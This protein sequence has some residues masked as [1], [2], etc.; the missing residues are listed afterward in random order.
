MKHSKRY[1][2]AAE[3]VDRGKFYNIDEAIEIIKE[4]T[5]SKFDE[6]IEITLNLGI[7]PRKSDQ[8]VRGAAALPFGT[9]KSKKVLVITRSRQ[10]EAEQA[11]ADFVGFEDYVEKI[12]EGW[13]EFDTVVATPDSMGEVGKLGKILGPKGLMPNPKVGTVTDNVEN[14]VKEIKA[15]KIEFR[16]DKYGIL[17]TI[18]GKISFDKEK[19]IENILTF[20]STVNKLK[21]ATAKGLYLKKVYLGSTMGPSLKIDKN[22]LLNRLK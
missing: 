14:A 22:E 9:G 11:G 19:L 7:D 15:G 6:S 1:N 18:V 4:I 8:M 3:K 17:H 13:L 20:I 10:S 2:E 12:K 5:K 21:P 16:V